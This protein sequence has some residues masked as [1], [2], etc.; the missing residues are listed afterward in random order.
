M[1]DMLAIYNKASICRFEQPFNCGLRLQPHLKNVNIPN[2]I[3]F[4]FIFYIYPLF[5]YQLMASS[6][7]WEELQYTWTE[8]RRKAGSRDM[9]DIYEQLVE[10]TNE[11][12]KQNSNYFFLIKRQP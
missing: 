5:I 8:F 7:D 6:R 11:A 1:N 10:L 4:T 2:T 9:R 3:Y 12:A